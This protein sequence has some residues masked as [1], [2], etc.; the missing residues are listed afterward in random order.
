M[1]VLALPSQN[2]TQGGVGGP[3]AMKSV[4]VGGTLRSLSIINNSL[5]PQAQRGEVIGWA[6]FD[7]NV[8]VSFLELTC[9]HDPV[10]V[11]KVRVT[12]QHFLITKKTQSDAQEVMKAINLKLGY[13]LPVWNEQSGLITWEPILDSG[14]VV[15]NG[16][17]L[18]LLT[19]SNVLVAGDGIIVPLLS[20]GHDSATHNET[21]D[22]SPQEAQQV[23]EAWVQHYITL[24]LEYPCLVSYDEDHHQVVVT[25]LMKQYFAHHNHDVKDAIDA[26]H[27]MVWLRDDPHKVVGQ[28]YGEHLRKK[29][30]KLFSE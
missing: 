1:G 13:L 3:I 23:Y 17:Y 16:V 14:I 9:G 5:V 10:H 22:L 12:A 28:A 24:R 4:R 20:Q 30:P 27:F 2:E 18:P 29:C 19:K 7:E 21:S 25:E 8:K 11:R 26:E 6:E 15:E